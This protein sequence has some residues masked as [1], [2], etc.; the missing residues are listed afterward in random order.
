MRRG[1]ILAIVAAA[2]LGGLSARAQDLPPGRVLLTPAQ[3]DHVAA[4]RVGRVKSCY[5]DALSKSPGLFGVLAVGFRVAPD[6]KVRERWIAMSTLGDPMLEKCALNAFDGLE[7]PAPG[8]DG[9]E[10][11]FGMLLSVDVKKKTDKNTELP[12]RAKIQEDAWKAAISAP[13]PIPSAPQPPP[14]LP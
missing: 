11:R 4:K 5:K 10:A 3:V 13:A 12:D 8:S 7:F 2:S 1:T 9:A 14:N 6:G